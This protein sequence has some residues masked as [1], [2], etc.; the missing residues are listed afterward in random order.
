ML[1]LLASGVNLHDTA[2][3]VIGTTC[4]IFWPWKD[5]NAFECWSAGYAT[6]A[7]TL[8]FW[9]PLSNSDGPLAYYCSDVASSAC[10][11]L[12]SGCGRGSGRWYRAG[13]LALLPPRSPWRW[14]AC[15]TSRIVEGRASPGLTLT[16]W[17][18]R[19]ARGSLLYSWRPPASSVPV[20]WSFTL[21]VPRQSREGRI[22]C[23]P[24]IV[25]V[26][27]PVVILKRGEI[28]EDIKRCWR[29]FKWML[30][31]NEILPLKGIAN[32][33][34]K[35]YFQPYHRQNLLRII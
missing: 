13:R 22:S 1:A 15:R 30:S 12:T 29:Q 26:I 11:R 19:E 23:P 35:Q 16:S 24:G 10:W 17:C 32:F 3:T 4:A 28:G 31:G 9:I 33:S 14:A 5:W 18:S 27:L 34:E 25:Y 2:T 6:P 20:T 7:A 21:S 8:V